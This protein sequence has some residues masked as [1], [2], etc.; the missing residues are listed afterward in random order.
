MEVLEGRGGIAPNHSRPRHW[1][2]VSGQR[3]APGGVYPREQG[4]LYQLYRRLGGPQSRFGQ[5][6]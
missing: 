1:W 4:P 5:R 6:G 2:G 3:H